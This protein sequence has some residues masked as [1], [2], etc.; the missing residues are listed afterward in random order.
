MSVSR[1][2]GTKSDISTDF[3]LPN[4]PHA[5]PPEDPLH[6][7]RRCARLQEHQRQQQITQLRLEMDKL[8]LIRH[9]NKQVHDQICAAYA[10][11]NQLCFQGRL[12]PAAETLHWARKPQFTR[13]GRMYGVN[14]VV[15]GIVMNE[16]I[17]SMQETFNTLIHEMVH[18]D[19]EVQ[20]LHIGS[21][22]HCRIFQQCV[23]GAVRIIRRNLDF[24][25]GLFSQ[26]LSV[27]LNTI[28]RT[29][30]RRSPFVR[31]P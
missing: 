17:P 7:R 23:S 10:R 16:S 26:Q 2:C 14:G 25:E 1:R 13:W 12:P 22:P 9:C 27:E 21:R 4:L 8:Q 5:T 28:A 3:T 20:R 11:I 30:S 15:V 6:R 29:R 31:T 18:A 24:F 19:V